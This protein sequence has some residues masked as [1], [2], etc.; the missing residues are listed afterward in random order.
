L[1]Q[2]PHCHI[3][4]KRLFRSRP[5]INLLVE[6]RIDGSGVFIAP[7]SEKSEPT[8]KAIASPPAP[9]KRKP[10]ASLTMPDWAMTRHLQVPDFAAF[11]LPESLSIRPTK[12][13][14]S[15][16]R[17]AIRCSAHAENAAQL[18]ELVIPV[19][20]R[21]LIGDTLERARKLVRRITPTL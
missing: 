21:I 19:R 4:I 5:A 20:F 18:V 15:E 10:I 17:A 3:K 14:E 6:F 11:K 7:E 13:D 12:F 8:P 2:V 16:V 1:R 9:P